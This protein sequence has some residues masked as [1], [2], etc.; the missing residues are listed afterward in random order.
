MFKEVFLLIYAIEVQT[1]ATGGLTQHLCTL[2]VCFIFHF[3]PPAGFRSLTAH[4]ITNVLCKHSVRGH[5]IILESSCCNK[6]GLTISSAAFNRIWPC[7]Q[8]CECLSLTIV[9]CDVVNGDKAEKL[10]CSCP[11]SCVLFFFLLAQVKLEM[12]YTYKLNT[13]LQLLDVNITANYTNNNTCY[14]LGNIAF[15]LL[16]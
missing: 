11:D 10:S 15:L 1:K 12:Y 14:R 7:S 9:I 5:Q 6:L 16:F 2:A 13:K 3:F 8:L 4:K